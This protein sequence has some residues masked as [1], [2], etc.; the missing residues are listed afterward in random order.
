[1]STVRGA[2]PE[3]SSFIGRAEELATLASAVV[4]G[5]VLTLTGAGGCGK[6]RLALR[7][8]HRSAAAGPHDVYW[9]GL[10]DLPHPD[11]VG[12]RV[13]EVLGVSVGG[14]TG[15]AQALIRA[16]RD[17]KLLL[18]LDNCEHVLAGAAALVSGVLQACPGV[19]VVATSRQALQVP[20][21]QAWLVP[22][23]SLPDALGLFLDRAGLAEA[24]DKGG[25][26]GGEGV[27]ANARAGVRRVCD[28]LD[29]LPLA[30]ELA[31]AWTAT[32]GIAQI[33]DLLSDPYALLDGGARTAP[34]R[35]RTLDESMRWSHDLLSHDEQV[36]FRRLAVFEPGFDATALRAATA[37]GG[38]D[39]LAA[40]KAL[41]GLVGA[42]LIVAD[43][44]GPAARYRMLE[45]IRAYGLARLTEVGETE[46]ARDAHLDLQLATLAELAPLLE[47]DRESWR[48]RV[49]AGYPNF[50][51]A[52][53][54]GL[55]RE[56][57]ADGRRLA[58][59]LAWL[60]HDEQ[61]GQ[62][63]LRLLRHAVELG[64]GQ[65]TALQAECL[66][67]LALVADTTVPGGEPYA[68]VRAALECAEEV[69]AVAAS[70]LARSLAA[71]GLLAVDL[72]RAR[73]E[74]VRARSDA[75][76]A[77]DAFV[78]H[79]SAAL[80][81]LLHL[82][83]DEYGAAVDLL[84][85]AADGLLALGDRGVASSALSWLATA[86]A[87][88]GH[89]DEAADVAEQ[90]VRVAAPL[91]ELHRTGLARAALVE[92]QVWQGRTV[93]A[94]QTLAALEAAAGEP[95]AVFIP[96]LERAQALVALADD[97]PADAL[98]W[99]ERERAWQ[100]GGALIPASQL[101]LARA[102]RLAGDPTGADAVLDGLLAS[103][104]DLP[105]VQA[106]ALAERALLAGDEDGGL[107]LQ[108]E[109]LRIRAAHQLV[110][111]CVDSL[112]AIAAL[113]VERG[114]EGVAGVL[115]GA[116]EQAR[117]EAGYRG[118][119]QGPANGGY[120]AD[121]L[122]RGRAMALAEA[123]TLAQRAR[124]P[125]RRPVAGWASLTP[126]ELSVAGL[127][128]QGLTNPDIA[129]RL[130]VSR[131][132][133]KTHLAHVYAKL[134]VANRTDLARLVVERGRVDSDAAAGR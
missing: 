125:R 81:G 100:P 74:A 24:P 15:S 20:G 103:A 32:L 66:V 75:L 102:R 71:V 110:L 76:A 115:A 12:D 33:A 111:G 46:A 36:L 118:Y 22:P 120:P 105:S 131:G 82:M 104:G 85:P 21:E 116:A 69:G 28:R 61:R 124:G 62:E 63:G 83:R 26:D 77:G 42:S 89:V 52:V 25:D 5:R 108:H 112:E 91:R 67:G 13:A 114:T 27:L 72:D 133:V 109:A 60:W 99:L 3:L 44:T 58:A 45:T 29:R 49:G 86:T 39:Q 101:L 65:R 40:L 79:A 30:I 53:E 130:Y 11:D 23:L 55:S 97:R 9:V 106:G 90:A 1:M 88:M 50:R 96:G 10:D 70:R 31:A 98:A 128:A 134:G 132:T 127:A 126:T 57:P 37:L 59:G 38:M 119:R 4:P 56:D 93:E 17:R 122:A 78:A 41:R 107:G 117:A 80:L 34:F 48:I 129:A 123:V 87:Q 121:A 47:S 7:L 43:T 8:A 54:W 2:P 51:T 14:D 6:T 64:R 113:L 16:L 19:A 84:R 92:I 68:A 94:A 35:Q 18:V 73:Q 95:E